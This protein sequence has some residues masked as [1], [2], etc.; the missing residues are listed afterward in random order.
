MPH[1]IVVGAGISGV[2]CASALAEGGIDVTLRERGRAV[3]GRMAS[4]TM[5]DTGTANDGRVVDI[6]ASYFTVSDPE[7][8][9]CIGGLVDQGIARPWTDAFHVASPQG[10]EGVRSGPMRYAANGGLRSVVA[11]LLHPAV[12]VVFASEVGEVTGDPRGAAVDGERV[13]A[14]AVCMPQPQAARLLAGAPAPG[15][16]EPVIV[17]T[18]A[19]DE[20]TWPLLDG[21]FVN[22][23]AV[24]TW[25]ADDGMRRGDDAP[26]LVVHVHPVLSAR[27][28]DD[29]TAV[30]PA[31]IAAVQRVLGIRDLPS[32]VEAH[33]WTYAKPLAGSDE[34]FLLH[35][36]GFV[37]LAGDAWSG[38]PRV[39][40]AWLSG[41]R[42]G[43]ALATRLAMSD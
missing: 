3:G 30:I 27:H 5:R 39:E 16:W 14:V 19:F 23:D 22:D 25:I 21:V 12:T 38:G 37:G 31:A 24:I 29:P 4:R 17:V 40:A 36:G 15:T 7:F 13:D 10:I 33:R 8:V 20:R 18:C 28:L 32:W 26:V 43:K 35:G 9:S 42:L 1:A 34:P 11:S 41:H 2:A 6:G